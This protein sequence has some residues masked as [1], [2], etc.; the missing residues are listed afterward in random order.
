VALKAFFDPRFVFAYPVRT[1]G[2]LSAVIGVYEGPDFAN[3]WLTFGFFLLCGSLACQRSSAICSTG[4]TNYEG[5]EPRPKYHFD[6]AALIQS[7]ALW[8][9]TIAFLLLFLHQMGLT[10]PLDAY[11]RRWFTT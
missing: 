10:L 4:N 3:R 6:W 8:M 11:I 9:L 7:V 5:E 2:M 1:I